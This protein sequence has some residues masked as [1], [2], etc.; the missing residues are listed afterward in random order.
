MP[1]QLSNGLLD[2]PIMPRVL[3]YMLQGWPATILMRSYCHITQRRTKLS[4]QDSCLLW[5]KS[6]RVVI[7]PPGHSS[8]LS[9]L[10]ETHPGIS[11]IKSLTRSYIWW[12]GLDK[13][14]E[15]EVHHCPQCR[16]YQW[17]PSKAPL[18]PWEWPEWPWAMQVPCRFRCMV[19]S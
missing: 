19:H 17:Q 16:E 11:R 12:P 2:D 14:L 3:Q 1:H 5:G 15:D 9:L 18:H 4:I 10:Y 7:P 6:N 13:V 8:K